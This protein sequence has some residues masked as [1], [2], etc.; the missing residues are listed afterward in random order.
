M[1]FF[2]LWGQN[3]LKKNVILFSI[4]SIKQLYFLSPEQNSGSSIEG[5][6]PLSSKGS[7]FASALSAPLDSS[8][9]LLGE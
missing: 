2:F 6:G 9:F 8:F 5:S 1:S 3:Q 7:S 4:M